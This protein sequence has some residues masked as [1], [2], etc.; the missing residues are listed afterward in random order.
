MG[1]NIAEKKCPFSRTMNTG[2]GGMQVRDWW[3]DNLKLNILRQHTSVTNPMDE[4]FDYVKAFNSIDYEGLKEDIRKVCRTSQPWWPAAINLH[5][6]PFLKALT[7]RP[8]ISWW[9]WDHPCFTR[10]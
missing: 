10:C 7:V 1:E 9:R 6:R 8:K 5:R 4:D 3:P 2:G